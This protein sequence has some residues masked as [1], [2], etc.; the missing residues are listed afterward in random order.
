MLFPPRCLLC[1]MALSS[2]ETLCSRC[3]SELE[4]T[5]LGER[6]RCEWCQEPLED[7]RADI[8]HVCATHDRGFDRVRSLGPYEGGWGELVRILKFA[9]ERRVAL[10]LAR[11]MTTYLLDK[12]PFGK[13]DA[14][15]YVPMRR[16]ERKRRGFNQAHLLARAL[17]KQLLIPVSSLTSKVRRTPPQAGLSARERRKNLR[18]AFRQVRFAKGKV[19]LVDDVYTT[20]ATVEE[21]AR[22]LKDGGHEAI[23][24]LT[25]ARS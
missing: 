25:V 21:C 22:T 23:C 24:V 15:T 14:I 6:F 2:W 20:G 12:R 13:I 9:K 7:L 10:L 19:L 17:G 5:R 4:R 8:C 11:Y 16:A 3:K 18:G 1:G